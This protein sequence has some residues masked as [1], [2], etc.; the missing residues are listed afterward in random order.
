MSG[1][2]QSRKRQAEIDIDTDS[3]YSLRSLSQ[4]SREPGSDG[5]QITEAWPTKVHV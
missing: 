3:S 2:N 1:Q 5:K 4:H